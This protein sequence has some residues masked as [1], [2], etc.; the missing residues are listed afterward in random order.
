METPIQTKTSKSLWYQSDSV[1]LNE[2]RVN[3]KKGSANLNETVNSNRI[4]AIKRKTKWQNLQLPSQAK[5]FWWSR[6]I[7]R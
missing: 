2:H 6:T 7:T 4:E 5:D 3:E 1:K